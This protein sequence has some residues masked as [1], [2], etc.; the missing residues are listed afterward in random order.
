MRVIGTVGLPGSGKGEAAAVAEELG[1]PVVTMGD[2]IRREC[3]DRGL[4]PAEHHGEIAAALREEN[5]PDAIAQRSLPVIEGALEA[6]DTVLVDGIRAGVEVERF[7]EAF[8]ESFTLVSIEAP[9]EV[10][11]E[12]VEA[13]GRDATDDGESLRERDERERGF[14]MGEAIARADVRIDNTATLEAF[15]EKIRALFEEGVAGLERE[16]TAREA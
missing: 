6:S 7:E 5:G 14:G 2:V 15:H 13:R 4:D 12:R 9:F 11:A 10:R 8:G 3:R 1:I 16:Q